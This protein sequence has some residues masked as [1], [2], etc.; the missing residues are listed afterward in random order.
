MVSKVGWLGKP[1]DAPVERSKDHVLKY[2]KAK[3]LAG[4]PTRNRSIMLTFTQATMKKP[5][6]C[7][8]RP[9]HIFA[10]LAAGTD[11]SLHSCVLHCIS[12]S[13]SIFISTHTQ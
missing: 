4:T 6:R 2:H 8:R 3:D 12:S 5:C 1:A 13:V 11:R 9:A 7:Q 10:A